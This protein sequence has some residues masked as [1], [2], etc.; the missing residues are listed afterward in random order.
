MVL[1]GCAEPDNGGG[2]CPALTKPRSGG[3][4]HRTLTGDEVTETWK[5]SDSPHI[6][7]YRS[8]MYSELTIEPCAY[9]LVEHGAN[10][11]VARGG[12]LIALGTAEQPIVFDRYEE[13]IP[14][15]QIET[16]YQE[17]N[18]EAPD[19]IGGRVELA[20]VTLNGGGGSGSSDKSPVISM[21]GDDINTEGLP[22]V[23]HLKVSHVTIDGGLIGVS[24]QQNVT[25][26]EGSTDLTIKNVDDVPI[27]TTFRALGSLPIGGTYTGNGTDV[28]EVRPGADVK[29][30]LTIRDAGVPYAVS[31]H[32]DIFIGG[33]VVT[34]E[35]GVTM[36]FADDQSLQVFDGGALVARGT[37][38]KPITFTSAEASKQPGDWSGIA[39]IGAPR[40]ENALDGVIV[41][42]AG[43]NN[44]PVGR[45]CDPA[46]PLSQQDGKGAI[47]FD[48]KPA[49]A[50]V[51][52]TTIKDSLHDGFNRGWKGTPFDLS[53]TNVFS[54]IAGCKQSFPP[55][56]A[57]ECPDPV[58]CI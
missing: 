40:A 4:S 6:V 30:D 22:L 43:G 8:V 58:P 19:E 38:A 42:Y 7:N 23:G 55:P 9:V 45:R 52:N 18:G 49:S 37:S 21:R 39:F 25:F 34:V 27:A 46:N 15:G 53:P 5:A 10:F 51:K 31:D 26:T 36:A 16:S 13:D 32:G 3:V 24:M 56:V 11:T 17:S 47:S 33:G 28:I 44:D 12:K 54:G 35:P 14:W 50:F 2:A 29:E 1:V 57:G 41:E 48:T 20:Y